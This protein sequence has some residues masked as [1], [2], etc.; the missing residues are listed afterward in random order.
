MYKRQVFTEAEI[1]TAIDRNAL[2]QKR[3]GT[4]L[5]VTLREA[6]KIRLGIPEGRVG[7]AARMEIALIGNPPFPVDV[8]MCIRDRAPG[9]PGKLVHILLDNA[10]ES[11]EPWVL[12][13]AGLK[14]D[15]GIL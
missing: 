5:A 3:V 15:I 2:R 13:F 6:P 7:I 9:Q 8:K 10:R 14:E 4:M 1:Q 12:R 11:I